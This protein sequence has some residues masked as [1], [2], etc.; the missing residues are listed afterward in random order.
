MTIFS[1]LRPVSTAGIDIFRWTPKY[2]GVVFSF[3][4]PEKEPKRSTFKTVGRP[5]LIGKIPLVRKVNGLGKISEKNK[6]GRLYVHLR[7]IFKFDLFS[8]NG[9]TEDDH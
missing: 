4:S 3:P 9:G 6:G 2:Y 7:E 1:E 5:Q 8:A